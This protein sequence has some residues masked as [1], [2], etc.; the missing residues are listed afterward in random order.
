[1][2]RLSCIV[3]SNL[4][5]NGLC[6]SSRAQRSPQA[7]TSTHNYLCILSLTSACLPQCLETGQSVLIAIAMFHGLYLLSH[8]HFVFIVSKLGNR[9]RCVNSYRHIPTNRS[10]R[11][12]YTVCKSSFG[13]SISIFSFPAARSVWALINTGAAP[14]EAVFA[15]ID[16][17]SLSRVR[18]PPI[19]RTCTEQ[20]NLLIIRRI[21]RSIGA[22]VCGSGRFLCVQISGSGFY[23][24]IPA[25]A[26]GSWPQATHTKH[27]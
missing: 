11:G 22:D 4:D 17:K 24:S 23:T 15:P 27:L 5:S 3:I 13:P 26:N 7:I 2:V 20:A 12:E 21:C 19:P 1:M 14:H 18:K 25:C 6:H 9:V 16:R 8:N 10:L